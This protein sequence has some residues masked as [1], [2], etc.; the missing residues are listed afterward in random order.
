MTLNKSIFCFCSLSKVPSAIMNV[1]EE[2]GVKMEN[3][4]SSK[5]INLVYFL[6][7]TSLY[8]LLCVS[9]LFWLDILPWYGYVHNVKEFGK[10]YVC[11]FACLFVAIRL[12]KLS[13]S[14]NHLRIKTARSFNHDAS[15]TVCRLCKCKLIQVA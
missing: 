1:L 6:F 15:T 9:S 13:A 14:Q 5:G 2:K 7:W 12:S 8:Q 11:L 3:K 4:T 10:K